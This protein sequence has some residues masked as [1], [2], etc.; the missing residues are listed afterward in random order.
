MADRMTPEQR[1]R[2]MSHIRGV[3]TK[4]E[5][6]VRRWLWK[7]GFRYR[8]HVR[9][10]PGSPDVVM[11]R[12]HTVIFVNGCFWHGH[13]NCPHYRLPHTHR[14]YWLDK[15]ARNRER[16]RRDHALLAQ[17][18]WHVLVVWECQLDKRRRHDTLLALSRRLSQIV[19]QTQHAHLYTLPDRE[20][21]DNALAAE[22]QETAYHKAH[23]P[24]KTA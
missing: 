8:L 11:R 7:Q 20:E 2:C 1:H 3:D 21:G 15:I 10:L 13:E 5:M 24:E 14:Q 4:P 19:M 16:D 22:P 23:S 6:V 18:G 9:R 12:W 17:A